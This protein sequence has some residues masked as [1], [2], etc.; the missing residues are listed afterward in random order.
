MLTGPRRDS[1]S[2]LYH[3]MLRGI[4]RGAIVSD[5]YFCVSNGPFIES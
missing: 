5:D 2:T 3:V 1:P 4:E